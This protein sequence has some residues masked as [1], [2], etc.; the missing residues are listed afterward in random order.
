MN[1]EFNRQTP[2][3]RHDKPNYM[4]RRIGVLALA[5]TL[6]FGAIEVVDIAKDGFRPTQFSENTKEYFVHP[7]D[8]VDD[9]VFQIEGIS[10]IDSREARD[11]VKKLPENVETL[12]DGLYPG[13]I[14]IIP[15]SVEKP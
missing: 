3:N 7:G 2:E 5:A 4:A 12:S 11:Y 15:E 8:G 14:L 13:E 10:K 9:A 1:Q 6:I